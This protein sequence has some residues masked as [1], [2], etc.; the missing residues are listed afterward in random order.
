M[1]HIKHIAIHTGGGD[2]PGLN[3]V[4]HAAVYAARNRG[5]EV[6][7]IRDGFEGLL[8]PRNYSGGGLVKLSRNVVRSIAHFGGTILGTSN[9]GNPLT[10]KGRIEAVLHKFREHKL[11][12][13]ISVSGG[14]GQRRGARLGSW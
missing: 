9:S 8:E 4:I 12:A 11:E 10:N 13:L 1:H 2:A 14:I 6:S 5:W 7:G 3:A